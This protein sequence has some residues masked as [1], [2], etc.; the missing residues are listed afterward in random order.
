ML[1]IPAPTA[2]DRANQWVDA[3]DAAEALFAS[4]FKDCPQLICSLFMKASKDSP[5]LNLTETS[6]DAVCNTIATRQA[7]PFQIITAAVLTAAKDLHEQH[8]NP[9]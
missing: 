4:A 2:K 7:I 6:L 9:A 1:R 5:Q 3:Y 8:H